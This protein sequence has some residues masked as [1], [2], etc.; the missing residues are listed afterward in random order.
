MCAFCGELA[1]VGVSFFPKKFDHRISGVCTS[2]TLF[3]I[4]TFVAVQA[5]CCVCCL[6][7]D[8]VGRLCEG[9]VSYGPTCGMAFG[10]FLGL[11]P[12]HDVRSVIRSILG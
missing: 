4:K 9:W 5:F 8:I 2:T 7:L 12:F 10:G 1:G 3:C 11:D 6:W